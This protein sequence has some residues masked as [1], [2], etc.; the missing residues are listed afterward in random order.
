[1]GRSAH[2]VGAVQAKSCSQLPDAPRITKDVGVRSRTRDGVF[3]TDP[4][5]PQ[6]RPAPTENAGGGLPKARLETLVDGVF[7]IAMTLLVLELRIPANK[8]VTEQEL[9]HQLSQ[10]LPKLGSI[11]LSF[12]ILGM[13]WVGHHNQYV[14]IR[15][16]DRPFLWI[17]MLFMFFI[18]LIPFSTALL[19][20]HPTKR[21]AMI[22]YSINVG[23]CGLI[24]L[25]HWIYAT[26]HR[27]LVAADLPETVVAATRRRVALAPIAYALAI[28]LSFVNEWMPLI[29]YVGLPVYFI[30]PGAVDRLWRSV[31]P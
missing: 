4:S 31:T 30:L 7:A 25:W 6:H 28:P 11:F 13:S 1:V 9:V 2:A 10:I 19:G 24:L 17:N 27:R 18:T 14:Y 5:R 29:V 22:V 12:V 20:D 8:G 23:L 16:T 26:A 15:R 3:S 21:T